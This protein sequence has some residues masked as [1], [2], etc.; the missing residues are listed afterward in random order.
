[1]K[2][3]GIFDVDANTSIDQLSEELNIKMPE[4]HQYETVSGFICEVFGYIPEEGGKIAMV[5]EKASPEEN[6]GYKNAESDSSLENGKHQKY[7][8]EIMEANAR[9]VGKVRFKAVSSKSSDLE[10][11]GINRVVSKKVVKRKKQIDQLEKMKEDSPLQVT[12]S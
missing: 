5:L 6:S 12:T 7:E 1:M 9:K 11:K 8:I 3:D 4:G 2:E 10:T